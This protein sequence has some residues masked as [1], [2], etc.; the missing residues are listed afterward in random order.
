MKDKKSSGDHTLESFK[1]YPYIAWALII[2]F[3]VFVY[4]ITTN[5]KAAAY[6][7]R[8]QS[9][10]SEMQTSPKPSQL[11]SAPQTPQQKK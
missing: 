6:D 5:L 9:D 7:L 3:A 8:I 10:I 1:I 11:K 4:T 2:G